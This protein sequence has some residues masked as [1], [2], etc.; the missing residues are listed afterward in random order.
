LLACVSVTRTSHLPARAKVI[1]MLRVIGPALVVRVAVANSESPFAGFGLPTRP[2]EEA[3]RVPKTI[4]SRKFLYL[5][6]SWEMA[7]SVPGCWVSGV[8]R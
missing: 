4:K 8:A 6:S 1:V 5:I 2:R 3:M 7:V